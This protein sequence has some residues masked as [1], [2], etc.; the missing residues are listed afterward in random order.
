MAAPI[1][2]LAEIELDIED[3]RRDK[4]RCGETRRY[5][6]EITPR[7]ARLNRLIDEWAAVNA[8]AKTR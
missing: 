4:I 5:P 2:T 6:T 1:R 8:L 3:A 7:D